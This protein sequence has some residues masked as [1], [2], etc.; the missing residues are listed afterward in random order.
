MNHATDRWR[1]CSRDHRRLPQTVRNVIHRV[2]I[3]RARRQRQIRAIILQRQRVVVQILLRHRRQIQQRRPVIRFFPRR[4]RKKLRRFARMAVPNSGQSKTIQ[5]FSVGGIEVK[6]RAET[7]FRRRE[8]IRPEL[9]QTELEP[10]FGRLAAPQRVCGELVFRRFR[11]VLFQPQ[12]AQIVMRLHQIAV[13]RQRA[14][15]SRHGV[16]RLAGMLAGHPEIIPRLRIGGQNRRGGL[17]LRR[18]P[19]VIAVFQ[20]LFPLEQRARTGWRAARQKQGQRQEDKTTRREDGE[21]RMEFF[22]SVP[23]SIFHLPSSIFADIFFGQ[24]RRWW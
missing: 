17:E 22:D 11:L 14:L 24:H 15:I 20:K 7:F 16:V 2:P 1:V 12:T 19:G 13:E 23:Y 21:W 6:H 8:I 10:A 5:G 9:R 18:R 3:R 4:L